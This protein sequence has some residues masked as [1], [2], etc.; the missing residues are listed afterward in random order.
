MLWI[1]LGGLILSFASAV[2]G[3]E[4]LGSSRGIRVGARLVR[5]R[6][7][8][9]SRLVSS[10]AGAWVSHF[11]CFWRQFLEFGLV[12]GFIIVLFLHR[13]HMKLAR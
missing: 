1:G 12:G 11:L 4:A 2:Y 7:G 9:H 5:E 6:R 10:L 13:G 8:G 3:R